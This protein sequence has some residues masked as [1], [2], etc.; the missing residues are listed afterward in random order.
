M[1]FLQG[2]YNLSDEQCE[3]QV[4]DRLSF[5]A[6]RQPEQ[7]L[8]LQTALHRRVA[9]RRRPPRFAAGRHLL[10]H[11]PVQPHRQRSPRPQRLRVGR[12]VRCLVP[13]LG[14]LA[15]PVSLLH[16]SAT[17]S[18]GGLCNKATSGGNRYPAYEIGLS[19]AVD[20][21]PHSCSGRPALDYSGQQ[22]DSAWTGDSEEA[23]RGRSVRTAGRSRC[24]IAA[25]Q[26]FRANFQF[27][28]T[29]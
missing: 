3:H 29:A 15:H 24:Q 5:L 16:R 22:V 25:V 12:P 27:L 18:Q 11:V 19:A 2:P 14:R 7:H 6:Q 28:G 10:R 9:V 20:I 23:G 21:M 4:L 8:H 26:Y 13:L 1:V 17:G